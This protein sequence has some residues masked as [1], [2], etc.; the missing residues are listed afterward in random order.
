MLE[1]RGGLTLSGASGG[2]HGSS[3][4]DGLTAGPLTMVGWFRFYFDDQR[5]E[6]SEV[7]QQLHGYVPG[8]IAPTTDLILA[9]KHPEDVEQVAAIIAYVTEHRG[10]FSSRHRI[11]DTAG[12][13]HWVVVVGDQFFDNDGTVVG[14]HGFYIDTTP[15][16]LAQQEMISAKLN[17]IADS[18]T[19]IEQAKG[20]L[21]LIYNIDAK[22]AFDL[23]R[24]LSQQNNVRIRLLAAQLVLDLRAVRPEGTRP[25]TTAYDH[26]LMTAHERIA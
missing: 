24:W 26:V 15:A 13:V 6:W 18:R 25:D 17:E 5:W 22:A 9:H 19:A 16:H 21:M 2:G 4:G 8:A 14:T 3:V 1:E 7:V 11:I 12:E 10:A 20:M 23:L